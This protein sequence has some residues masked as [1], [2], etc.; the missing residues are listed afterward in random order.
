MGDGGESRGG[1]EVSLLAAMVTATKRLTSCV[2]TRW[3]IYKLRVRCMRC[4]FCSMRSSFFLFCFVLTYASLS[5]GC[6][7]EEW[8]EARVHHLIQSLSRSASPSS[9]S[10]RLS[11]VVVRSL[12]SLAFI[13]STPLFLFRLNVRRRKVI[14]YRRTVWICRSTNYTR[15][16]IFWA[17]SEGS[18]S[19][20]LLC[21]Q[22]FTSQVKTL[23]H[24]HRHVS[25]R[26][27]H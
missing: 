16:H 1:W 21:M 3:N 27:M 2:F 5:T 12:Y 7:R 11:L 24:M 25:Y 17:R 15:S 9:S 14:P 8:A 13:S 26:V 22:S 18:K 23:C 20:A 19:S 10:F 4:V 6:K